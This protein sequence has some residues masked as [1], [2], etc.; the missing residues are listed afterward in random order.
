MKLWNKLQNPYVLVAQ[1]F[2]LGGLIFA[3][4]HG[5]SDSARAAAPPGERA[6]EMAGERPGEDEATE[7]L[8]GTGSRLFA[9]TRT[10]PSRKTAHPLDSSATPADS[11]SGRSPSHVASAALNAS[12]AA[13][14]GAIGR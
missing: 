2:V 9:T 11:N 3:A 13:K 4:T 12:L 14:S 6:R 8:G 5:G 7:S 10:R 1:G